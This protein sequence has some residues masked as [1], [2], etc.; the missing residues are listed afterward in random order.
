M[1]PD[2]W[3]PRTTLEQSCW[4]AP[5][6]PRMPMPCRMLCAC[7]CGITPPSRSGSTRALFVDPS[8]AIYR[9]VGLPVGDWSAGAKF[10]GAWFGGGWLRDSAGEALG[11]RISRVSGARPDWQ[12]I[13]VLS[14]SR[15]DGTDPSHGAP[16]STAGWPQ[17]TSAGKKI[18]GCG[19]DLSASLSRAVQIWED[20]YE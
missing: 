3:W 17:P 7:R 16:V 15:P 14:S 6:S 12:G 11:P 19:T 13:P 1:S 18:L 5:S 10:P 9:T 8:P 20:H 4:S 2:K